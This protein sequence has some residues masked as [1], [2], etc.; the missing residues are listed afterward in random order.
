MSDRVESLA[1]RDTDAALII[2]ADYGDEQAWGALKAVLLKPWGDEEFEQYV[3]IVDD[4]RWAGTTSA[5]VL[6]AVSG[7]KGTGVVFLADS[8]SMR[9][10]LG[11]LLAIAV[12]T[13]EECASDE[14]FEA[15]GGEFRTVPAG[16]R[17]IHANLMIANLDFGDFADSARDDA[18]GVFRGFAV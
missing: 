11:A 18:E 12:L 1:E 3:H 7:E 2:R 6:S 9:G 13:R 5:E 15:Y 14:E 4:P 8:R 16:V 10:E 17:E